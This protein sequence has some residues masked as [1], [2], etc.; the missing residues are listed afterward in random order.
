VNLRLWGRSNEIVKIRGIPIII[1][2]RVRIRVV[3]ITLLENYD[4]WKD[5]R[6]YYCWLVCYVECTSR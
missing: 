6:G 4:V 3:V 2:A 5:H 1:H